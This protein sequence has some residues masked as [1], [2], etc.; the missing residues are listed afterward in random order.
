MFPALIAA[1][2]PTQWAAKN[3]AHRAR[4]ALTLKLPARESVIGG[5]GGRLLVVLGAAQRMARGTTSISEVVPEVVLCCWISSDVN[6]GG[7]MEVL[8]RELDALNPSEFA[9]D[10][11]GHDSGTGHP[12][13][14]PG[15]VQP[16]LI[17][18]PIPRCP[19]GARGVQVASI[20]RP[21]AWFGEPLPLGE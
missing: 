16:L 12:E 7:E 9:F 14:V 19:E 2:L 13:C 20:S 5:P 4:V 17:K 21:G 10:G 8:P 1:P 15:I 6:Q 11:V 18:S 3:A